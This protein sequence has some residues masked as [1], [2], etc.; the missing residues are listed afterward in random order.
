MRW[1]IDDYL[2]LSSEQVDIVND[3]LKKEFAWHRSTQLALIQKSLLKLKPRIGKPL[4]VAELQD[5]Y[6]DAHKHSM[7]IAEHVIPNSA[8]LAL[9][10]SQNQLKVL[11]RKFEANNQKFIKQ[12]VA[13]TPQQQLD[14]RVEKIIDSLEVVYGS[15]SKGQ[16]SQISKL[17]EEHPI[18]IKTVFNERI[19]RQKDLLAI[20]Q[21][22]VDEKP[23]LPATEAMLLKLVRTFELGNTTEQ[24]EFETTRLNSNFQLISA[25]TQIMTEAQRRQAQSRVGQWVDDVQVL[26]SER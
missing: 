8:K 15:M 4:T 2:D 25:I 24:K 22:V 10:L 13:G 20:L 3:S 5:S 26:I 21:K 16:R 7:D 11:Q 1:W 23:S 12:Y 19:R 14:A 9:L 17:V 6:E 18:D